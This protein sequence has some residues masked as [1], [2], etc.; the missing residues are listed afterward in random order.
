MPDIAAIAETVFREEWGR[1]VAG[2]I[3]LSGSFDLAEEAAQEAF[4]AALKTWPESGL[5][6]NP[7][8]WITTVAHRKLID[9]VRK[10]SKLDD[11]SALAT[12]AAKQEE[13]ADDMAYPDLKRPIQPANT[14]TEEVPPGATTTAEDN[15]T[16]N[17]PARGPND[18]TGDPAVDRTRT[19]DDPRP[20]RGS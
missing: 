1:I 19:I 2:L 11:D 10:N 9:I 20:P 17:P 4:T 13:V 12:M 7:A 6:R 5:P 15:R 14:G 8:A 18:P 16:Q 3:R